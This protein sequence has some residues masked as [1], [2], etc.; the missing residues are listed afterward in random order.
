MK[1]ILITGGTGLIGSRLIKEIDK[2]VYQI[3]ILTR[4]KISDKNGIKYIQWDPDNSVLDISHVRNL[5]SIINLAGESIDGSRW[6]SRYKRK[7]L[8]SRVN[9]LKLLQSKV[10]KLSKLPESFVSAS[11]TGYYQENTSKPQ[12]ELDLPGENF[13]SKVVIE[14]EKE[15]KK[16]DKIGVRTVVLRIGLVL[17]RRGGVLKKLYPLF[18]F[19]LG[20]PIGSGKQ[21]ISWIHEKDMVDVIIKAVENTNFSGK[22]NVVA[23][24][25]VTNTEFTKSLLKTL[26][27]FSYPNFVKAPSFV[28]KIIFGEQSKLVL[29]GLNV[30]SKKLSAK[31]QFKF[32]ELD[33]ALGEIFKRNNS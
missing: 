12:N 1:S 7:I 8:E 11:A 24:E 33:S 19:F 26:G 22:F 15:M 17:S 27:R 6:T 5:Y 2:S 3:Y 25:R 23:P 31:Y 14:W 20:V 28:I 9:S 32:P 16:F 13:L 21:I 10:S 18:K 4:K 30:S 29:N